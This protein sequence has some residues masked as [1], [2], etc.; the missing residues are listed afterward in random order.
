MTNSND[1]PYDVVQFLEKRKHIE[2]WGRKLPHWFQENKT[3]FV[4]FRLADSL[5]KNKVEELLADRAN[6]LKEE[7][8]TA[9]NNARKT[10]DI[11]MMRKMEYWLNNGYGNCML[12]REDVRSVLVEALRVLYALQLD[13]DILLLAKDDKLGRAL[14]DIGLKNRQR[15]TKK[16]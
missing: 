13:D 9:G 1:I 10:Y 15:A 8:G 5:P 7:K 4:T 16:G 11:M 2:I 12:Q 6:M 3:M 14:Q